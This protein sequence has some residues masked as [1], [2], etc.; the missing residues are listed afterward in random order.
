MVEI[1]YAKFKQALVELAEANP[2]RIYK[3]EERE[4]NPDENPTCVNVE[5]NEE[6][7][8]YAGSCLIGSAFVL[9]GVD[10][11]DMLSVNEEDS[12]TLTEHLE[13]T[14]SVD[15]ALGWDYSHLKMLAKEAQQKQDKG[16]SWSDAVT[17]AIKMVEV[18][19][20]PNHFKDGILSA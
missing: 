2:D 16:V 14:G 10:P 18:N 9:L 12:A 15:F 13:E 17:Y 1:N 7:G 4:A 8:T 20:Y 3:Q 5:F 19:G 6:F 11:E